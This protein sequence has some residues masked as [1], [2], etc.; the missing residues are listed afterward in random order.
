MYELKTN[1][2]VRIAVGPLVD[3]TDGKTAETSL[4][5]T[6]MSAE[7]FQ[8]KTDGTAVVRAA[9][10]PSASG[11]SNDMVHVTDD[12]TGM[13]D[14]ELT[15]AQLNWYGNGRIAFYDVDGFLIHW[16]DIHVVAANYFDWKYGTGN[17]NTDVIAISGDT[18]AANNLEA[19]C[20]GT[21]YNI[22]GGA[23]VAASVTGAVGSVTGAV[24]SVTG[25]VGSVTGAVGSVTTVNGIANGA[26]TAAAIADNAI[27]L[28]TFAADCKTGSALKANVE[29]IT[30]GAI[31]ATA[32]ADNAIDLATFAADCKTGSALKA[33]VESITNG[34]ITAAAIATGAIDADALAADAGAEIA[35]AVWDEALAG[36]A[37][38]GTAGA[39][40]SAAGTAGDPWTT[41]L[42]GIYGAGTAGYILGT[43]L[44][45]KIS[46][47]P[48]AAENADA[49]WDEVSTGH[50]DAGKAGTQLWTDID[51]ILTDTGTT[52]D[53]YIKRIL[54]L[55]HENFT[56]S[57]P[58][59]NADGNLT[60]ATITLYPT[61]AD[62]NAGTN[63]IATYAIVATYDV[64][65]NLATYKMTQET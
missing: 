15:A 52:L 29:T 12:T 53:T 41:A 54:G 45:G 64:D 14:L 6:G 56:I 5:V 43:N 63:A 32:I 38:A 17:V 46:D 2:A 57:A 59:F 40:L 51:A 28:A 60:A 13:Y 33:N 35:D 4:T 34:A 50:T 22:G 44:D 9:F 19:A 47:L 49:V 21:T 37:G 11:G 58:T 7:I 39:T 27:D 61:K 23:V 25:S 31:T 62:T 26:I 10:N 8:I 18:T 65:T 48:T 24:G 55:S 30:A 20:D 16:I 3:P 42:P 1:T 36:H